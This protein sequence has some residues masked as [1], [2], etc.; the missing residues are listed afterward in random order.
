MRPWLSTAP[1]L[2][3][4]LPA[5]RQPERARL[6]GHMH[7]EDAA[8]LAGVGEGNFLTSPEAQDLLRI[9][10]RRQQAFQILVGQ[11]RQ[12]CLPEG[13]LDLQTRGN[14]GLQVEVRLVPTGKAEELVYLRLSLH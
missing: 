13:T 3:H 7:A 1:W 11:R 4:L 5:G 2:G 9:Q 8:L 14:P 10:N 6:P 12:V